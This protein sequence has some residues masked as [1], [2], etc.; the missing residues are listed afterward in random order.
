MSFFA[1]FVLSSSLFSEERLALTG[2]MLK[3]QTKAR[4]KRCER[5]NDAFATVSMF[6]ILTFKEALDISNQMMAGLPENR[7]KA[8]R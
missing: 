3:V 6:R 2:P 4:D 8:I 7:G 1:L 5:M